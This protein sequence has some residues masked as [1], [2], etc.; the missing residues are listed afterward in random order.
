MKTV[1]ENLKKSTPAGRK[2]WH[3]KKGRRDVVA[4]SQATEFVKRVPEGKY[5]VTFDKR[6]RE[7]FMLAIAP[8]KD[9]GG[10]R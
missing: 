9:E 2:K 10:K 6:T 5:P 1:A 8:L 4:P 7:A 3:Y